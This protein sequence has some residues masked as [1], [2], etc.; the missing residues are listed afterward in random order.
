[1]TEKRGE[2]FRYSD[3]KYH[4]GDWCFPKDGKPLPYD[5]L[6]MEVSTWYGKKKVPGWWTGAQ[7]YSIKTGYRDEIIRWR[8][9][10]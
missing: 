9:N 5:L 7:W 1:M 2:G 10:E 6:E 8:R 3:L 4:D